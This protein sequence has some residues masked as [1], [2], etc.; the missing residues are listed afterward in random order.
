MV[1]RTLARIVG[2]REVVSREKVVPQCR[3]EAAPAARTQFALR[4]F[5]VFVL[6][7]AIV[8]CADTEVFV[9]NDGGGYYPQQPDFGRIGPTRPTCGAKGSTISGTVFAP[10][11][12]DPVPGATIFVPSKVP[13]FFSPKVKCEVCGTL[14]G[15]YN[16]WETVS[17]HDGKF[18]LEGVCPGQRHL[19]I[20]NGRFR[21]F[22]LINVQESSTIQ[23]TKEQSRLP[24]KNREFHALDSI[25]K[26]GAI[27]GDFDKMECVLHKMGLPKESILL[28]EGANDFRHRSPLPIA[29]FNL[30]LNDLEK[31]KEFNILFINCT[32]NTFEKELQKEKVRNNIAAY[33][34]AGG[35]LYVTDWSYDW[36]EQ[37]A[38][39]APFVDFEP[40][41]SSSSPEK[42]NAASIGAGNISIGATVK[43]PQL[44]KW[45][46]NFPNTIQGNAVQIGHFLRGWVMLNSLHKNVKTWVTGKVRSQDFS[47][48]GERPLTV[49]FNFKNCGKIVFSSYH[50]EGRIGEGSIFGPPA[51]PTYCG[52]KFSPQERILEYLIFDIANCVKPV[53]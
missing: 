47:I 48:N 24:K 32:D 20:Q 45:L 11:G 46:G 53:K 13:E 7:L 31:M 22:Q 37:I 50:T 38:T 39:L 40:G 4:L 8:A 5:G 29:P 27:V 1:W 21:R 41:K 14:G 33:V 52:T 49:S 10:N 12:V 6:G 34:S 25:P 44:A 28:G 18:T 30:L 17:S 19:A 15:S 36:I 35:R 26:V 16:F 3:P 23:L 9:S 42:Q 2:R 51:F 43:D